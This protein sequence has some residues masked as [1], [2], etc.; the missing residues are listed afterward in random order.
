MIVPVAAAWRSG[1][2][3]G[4]LTAAHACRCIQSPIFARVPP[5]VVAF[6][7]A[8]PSIARACELAAA[9][10]SDVH[11]RRFRLANHGWDIVAGKSAR[12]NDWLS[13][14]SA[15]RFPSAPWFHVSSQPGSHVIALPV[16]G[17]TDPSSCSRDVRR[18]AAGLAVHF[19]K[20]RGGGTVAVTWT[21]C[22]NVS[23]V[24]GSP[25]GQVVVSRPKKMNVRPVDPASSSQI[26][27]V[28]RGQRPPTLTPT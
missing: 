13:I 10:P 23:K 17:A 25:T 14:Q 16:D 27:V 1:W 3:G 7:T 11:L 18:T 22:G 12:D 26:L 4:K 21:T 5:G 9:A 19:S 2:V 24:K 28:A 20:A 8:E 15:R 6:S